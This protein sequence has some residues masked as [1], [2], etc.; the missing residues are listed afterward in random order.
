MKRFF[1]SGLTLVLSI[2][3]ISS[4]AHAKQVNLSNSAADLN[5]DG[6]VTLTELELYNRDQ[7][8]N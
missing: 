3:A 5:D 7:R 1:I 2:F 6:V 8:S 4:I